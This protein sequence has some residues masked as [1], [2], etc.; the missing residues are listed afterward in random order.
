MM[1]IRE[2]RIDGYAVVGDDDRIADADG[3]M[4]DELK[5]D[6]EWQFFQAGLDA[7]DVTV[8]GR[9]SHDITP[10]PKRRRRL[11]MTRSIADVEVNVAC[12]LWNPAGATL[13][14][15]L[16]AFDA[17]IN[18]I[19]VAGGREVFDYFLKPPHRFSCFNL[20]RIYGVT[21]PDG[22]GVFTGVDPQKGVLAEHILKENGFQP[23][24]RWIL[25][26]DVDVVAWRPEEA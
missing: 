13:D 14:Q 2:L 8:L 6:A 18:S 3:F 9:K 22:V 4:P 17:P 7:C 1:T 21:L 12:I 19:A 26:S 16:Q 25:D 24:V 5:N 15:A 10:N 23:G 20:S 11:V